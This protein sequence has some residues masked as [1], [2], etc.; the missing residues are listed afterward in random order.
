MGEQD[1]FEASTDKCD[2][3]NDKNGNAIAT[4]LFD[5]DDNLLHLGLKNWGFFPWGI[6]S[7]AVFLVFMCPAQYLAGRQE[8][9]SRLGPKAGL[10]I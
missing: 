8:E 6:Y 5:L 7:I 10:N 3:F 9:G 1:E 2:D 4:Q